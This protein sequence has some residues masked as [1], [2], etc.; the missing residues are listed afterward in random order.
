MFTLLLFPSIFWPSHTRAD[1]DI[2]YAAKAETY[3]VRIPLTQEVL[4]PSDGHIEQSS[5]GTLAIRKYRESVK[6]IRKLCIYQKRDL[7][8]RVM[9]TDSKR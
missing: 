1:L 4:N 5:G 6:F 9:F 8:G 2:A 7:E 3:I